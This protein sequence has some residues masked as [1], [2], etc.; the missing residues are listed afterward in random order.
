MSFFVHKWL[1]KAIEDNGS[2]IFKSQYKTIEILENIKLRCRLQK[3][4]LVQHIDPRIHICTTLSYYYM[5]CS[6]L[7]HAIFSQ[8]T[9][10]KLLKLTLQYETQYLY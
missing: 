4:T 3:G 9:S 1:G 6:L 5:I 7:E 2:P 8:E 10:E